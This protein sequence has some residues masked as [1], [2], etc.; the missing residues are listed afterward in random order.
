M[1][2]HKSTALGLKESVVVVRGDKE[3][4]SL[5]HSEGQSGLAI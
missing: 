3:P 1:E 2:I 5:K 4:S